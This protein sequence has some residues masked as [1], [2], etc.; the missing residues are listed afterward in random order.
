M[1]YSLYDSKY[2]LE[3]ICKD[4]QTICIHNLRCFD[5]QLAD[6]PFFG[7]LRFFIHWADNIDCSVVAALKKQTVAL[8]EI[9]FCRNKKNVYIY[10]IL[11]F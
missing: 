11:I 2:L 8:L 1:T 6:A 4:D 10:V 7:I 9:N 5:I 3:D